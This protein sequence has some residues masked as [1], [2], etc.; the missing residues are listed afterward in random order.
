MDID[1]YPIRY[2]HS[3]QSTNCGVY[4]FNICQISRMFKLISVIL[5]G[6]ILFLDRKSYGTLSFKTAKL[7]V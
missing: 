2:K 7:V 6:V 3:Q 5:T 4:A 1:Q